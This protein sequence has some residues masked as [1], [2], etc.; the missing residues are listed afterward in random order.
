MDK[1]PY[2]VLLKELQNILKK[3]K[4]SKVNANHHIFEFVG[5]LLISTEE[6]VN[7]RGQGIKPSV[8]DPDNNKEAL[9]TDRLAA[10]K[11]A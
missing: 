6:L 10:M 5:K 1:Y 4:S 2:M 3:A 11:G 8:K 7:L 9:H